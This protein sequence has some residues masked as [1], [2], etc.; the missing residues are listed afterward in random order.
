MTQSLRNLKLTLERPKQSEPFLAHNTMVQLDGYLL[1]GVQNLTLEFD[2]CTMMP[3]AYIDI[4]GPAG[5]KYEE[6]ISQGFIEVFSE[7]DIIRLPVTSDELYGWETDRADGLSWAKLYFP[8][9]LSIKD[10]YSIKFD[11]E[12]QTHELTTVVLR[13]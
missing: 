4:L 9:N 11:E 8:V 13:P 5:D 10:D 7:G 3:R 1:G 2:F 6:S 12:D